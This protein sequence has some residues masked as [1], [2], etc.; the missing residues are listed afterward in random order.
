MPENAAPQP[1]E[2]PRRRVEELLRE[3]KAAAEEEGANAEGSLATETVSDDDWRDAVRQQLEKM[4]EADVA[5]LLERLPLEDRATVWATIPQHLLGGVLLEV[6]EP[7]CESLIE[8]TPTETMVSLLQKMNGDDV[9]ALMRELPKNDAARLMRLAGLADNS[10]VRASLAFADNTVGAL[11]D[12]QPVL[13]RE[14]ESVGGVC[15]RLQQRRE[16]PSHCDKLFI[17]DDWERLA[18]VLPLKWLLLNSPEARVC[19]IMIKQNLH[20]F[21]PDDEVEDA[22]GAFERYDLITAPVL[23]GKHKI[24]GRLTIDEIVEYMHENRSRDL[25]NSAGVSDSE[26]LFAPVFQRFGN[27]WLWLF[28]NLLAAFFIS[29]VVGLFE[30]T[31]EQLVAL[32]ALMPVV[33]GMSGNIGNQTATLTVRA[34]ALGQL[35]M[36]NWRSAMRNELLLSI[37]NGCLWGG[38]VGIYAY[39]LYN[40][41]DLGVVMVVSMILCFLSGAAAGFAVPV[42]MQRFG[43]DPALGTTVVISAVTDTLGFLIFLGMGALFLL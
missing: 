29:R 34:L 39:L 3:N 26:D 24:V 7:L 25:L 13:A 2:D 22:A 31:I 16:L 14:D 6:S 35:S 28:V 9:A 5:D 1:L 27:R 37:V 4:H 42:I 10:D 36:E 19:D 40:R 38:L 20:T 30:G 18:G 41:W 11:M 43:R 17:V 23:D 15:A 32:A 8:L 21:S 12:Y 33:A